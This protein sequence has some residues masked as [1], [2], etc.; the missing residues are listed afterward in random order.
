MTYEQLAIVILYLLGVLLTERYVFVVASA[1]KNNTYM[2]ASYWLLASFWP[3]LAFRML[4]RRGP[5]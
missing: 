5:S 1:D 4:L 2:S 3:F